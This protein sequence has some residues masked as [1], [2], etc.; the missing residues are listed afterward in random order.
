MAKIR[1][2]VFDHTTSLS[3]DSK[4]EKVNYEIKNKNFS[5][6]LDKTKKNHITIANW[7]STGTLYESDVAG[8]MCRLIRP[9]DFVVDVGANIGFHSFL[10]SALVEESGKVIAYEPGAGAINEWE[11]NKKLN[12]SKNVVLSKKL[13]SDRSEDTVNFCFSKEDSGTSYALKNQGKVEPAMV[14]MVTSCLDNELTE[15]VPIKLIKI[16]VEGFEGHILRGA[17]KLLAED[18]VKYWVV[19]YAPHCLARNGD[20]LDSLR[21]TMS[22]YGLDMFL[23]D[24]QGGFPKVWPEGLRMHTR[25]IPNLLFTRIDSLVKDWVIDDVTRFVSPPNLW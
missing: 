25:F 4:K 23:L 19:E 15:N 3:Y 9:G 11:L 10:M 16:D 18:R 24:I 7:L 6:W 12:K 8:I 17:S 5:I 20:S 14:P 22:Q 13:L 21:S 1:K 2:I